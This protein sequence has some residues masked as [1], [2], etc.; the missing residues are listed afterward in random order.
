MSN[1]AIQCSVD[2]CRYNDHD[3]YCTLKDVAIGNSKVSEA[4][5]SSETEC[6]SF[7]AE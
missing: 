1:P 6:V 5:M 2:S 3:S 4:H 7:S